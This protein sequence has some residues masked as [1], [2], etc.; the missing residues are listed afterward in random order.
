MKA[1]IMAGGEGARLRPLTCDMP[2]PMM[3]VLDRPIMDYALRLLK[4]HGVS[5]AAVTLG[6]MPDSIRDHFGD[7]ARW[8]VELRYHV[9]KTPLGTAGGVK[10]ASG[11]LD[12]TF[13]VLSGDGLTDCDLTAALEFH[14]RKAADIT[15]VL[16]RVPVPLEYGV[17]ET[18]EGGRV[19]RFVE[20]PGWGEVFTD[21]VNTGIYIMEPDVLDMIPPG[22]YD[23][24]RELLPRAVSEG[25]AVYG[26]VMGG[27]WCDIG[28]TAAY[29]QANFD[30]LTGRVRGV[31]EALGRD[32]A[33]DAGT[34]IM[35]GARVSE[36]A[37]ITP[38]CFIGEG[39]V[40]EAGASVGEL[41]I[42]GSNAHIAGQAGIKH[43]VLMRGAHVAAGAQLRGALV[44]RDCSVGEGAC[45]YEQGVL[46]DRAELGERAALMPGVKVWPRKKAAP[47]A[48][49]EQN[50][51]WGGERGALFG[52]RGAAL[53]TP[54]QAVLLGQAYAASG[55][56]EVV[57]THAAGSRAEVMAG[58]FIAGLSA[59]GARV[60]DAGEAIVPELR[61]M[62]AILGA[63][64]AHISSGG[65][66]LL[67][68][69]G[70]PPDSARERRIETL[71]MRQDFARP[72]A[73]GCISPEPVLL[74]EDFFVRGLLKRLPAV[75]MRDAPGVVLM[76]EP[77]AVCTRAAEL[78]HALGAN[79]RVS[80]PML[81]EGSLRA[82][83]VGFVPDESG[84]T[85]RIC[86]AGGMLSEQEQLELLTLIALDQGA[87]EICVPVGST[88]A[89]ED[90][91]ASRGAALRYTRHDAAERLR[92]MLETEPR[93]QGEFQAA[94][95]FD[96]L[97]AMAQVLILI[98]RRQLPLRTL[99]E[100][101]PQVYRRTSAVPVSGADRGRVLRVLRGMETA[102][103]FMDGIYMR[104]GDGFAWISPDAHG[105]MRVVCEAR[106]GDAARR[107]CEEYAGRLREI[108]R[109]PREVM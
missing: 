28:D 4:R 9:E 34:I 81:F 83:E 46:G 87:Q 101:Y 93:E 62:E 45:I 39:A 89:L 78:L 29:A 27:Y 98:T 74:P 97:F 43:S 61:R 38:P 105:D 104:Q 107:M 75:D 15:I 2:K 42:I 33:D 47:G 85:L 56:R 59:Q 16:K 20:K 13:C 3:P 14:R 68:E 54:G 7:G 108:L 60:F 66:L 21:T 50:L 8:G 67:D 41:S 82:G 26:W 18:D 31:D 92:A 44:G 77:G 55:A 80:A 6:Y 73:L 52:L 70:L 84:E 96:A 91:A 102:A 37:H 72:F 23:F 22:Q 36:H 48:R 109:A 95:H 71:F 25:R 79:Y 100:D 57:V 103:E 99:T 58:A 49:L 24:G 76:C 5:S 53:E 51:V 86:D 35:P 19:R 90:V 64:G 30:A 17:V 65:A 88:R 106:D 10:A 12:E 40:I 69:R 11:F 63:A 94:L 32:T 1:V